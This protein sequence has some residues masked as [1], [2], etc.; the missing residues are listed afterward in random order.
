MIPK[1]L[2]DFIRYFSRLPGIGNKTSE[3]IGFFLVTQ[4]DPGFVQALADSIRE[5]KE[6]TKVCSECGG[7]SD[8][9]PCDICSDRSR[10]RSTICV[11]ENALDI[12]YIE[13]TNSYKGLYHVLGGVI[14]PLNGVLPKDLRIEELLK[15]IKDNHV[16][17]LLFATSATTEGDT[18]IL[19]IKELVKG[20]KITHLA[21]GIPVG[22]GL[23]YAGNSSLVQAI[24]SREEVK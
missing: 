3:R 21:R 19:Y 1:K 7:I 13:P 11:V 14:S 23:Q 17:E 18:T 2:G 15:R 6:G 20:V 9:D 16:Q 24:R 4:K 22:T 8:D 12:Y 5:L 10:D